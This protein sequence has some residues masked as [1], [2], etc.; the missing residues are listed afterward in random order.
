MVLL[1]R[2]VVLMPPTDLQIISALVSGVVQISQ[3]PVGPLLPAQP[4]P[5]ASHPLYTLTQPL[6]RRLAFLGSLVDR[7]IDDFGLPQAMPGAFVLTNKGINTWYGVGLANPVVSRTCM[8]CFTCCAYV[9]SMV[10]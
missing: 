10:S 2:V 4:N 7:L 5:N 6:A 1:K 8:Y 3:L 9:L